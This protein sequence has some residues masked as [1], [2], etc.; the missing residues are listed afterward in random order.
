MDINWSGVEGCFHTCET[1]RRSSKTMVFQCPRRFRG[2]LPFMSDVAHACMQ[3]VVYCD[4]SARNKYGRLQLST[5]Q[6]EQRAASLGIYSK[7]GTLVRGH[8]PTPWWV[9]A[10][11]SDTMM[12]RGHRAVDKKLRPLRD[13]DYSFPS[14]VLRLIPSKNAFESLR[15]C[16]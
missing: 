13:S 5:R 15:H 7:F 11:L 1:R 12:G 2:Y 6:L 8:F 10:L 14:A 9:A 3:V 4:F 16:W